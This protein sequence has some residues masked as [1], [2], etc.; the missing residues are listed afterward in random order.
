MTQ[1][2]I[3]V[4]KWL[5]RV[6][7]LLTITTLSYHAHCNMTDKLEDYHTLSSLLTALGINREVESSVGVYTH[8]AVNG[9]TLS[10]RR[11]DLVL[12]SVKDK[13]TLDDLTRVRESIESRYGKNKPANQDQEVLTLASGLI[14][15]V[16][17]GYRK[18]VYNDGYGT[19][20]VG[21]GSTF[22]YDKKTGKKRRVKGSDKLTVQE[23]KALKN[24]ILKEDYSF[25]SAFLE[26]HEVR[27]L[28]N[29][30]RAALV[31]FIYN[32]GR[33]AF[34]RSEVARMLSKNMV[35]QAISV[36][37]GSHITSKGRLAEGLVRRRAVEASLLSATIV[38]KRQEDGAI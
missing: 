38:K 35:R 37:K 16:E 2:R 26:K 20:T 36:M 21:L 29:L 14:D 31:S 24:R 28:D 19:L 30:S 22:L 27:P 23:G 12:L 3:Q 7:M 15:V 34:I 9:R 8:N 25:L 5:V 18:H 32:I 13:Q 1:K 17:G 11:F 4:F 10:L 6:K 33:E